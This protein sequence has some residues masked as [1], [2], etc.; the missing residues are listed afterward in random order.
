VKVR[1]QV[2]LAAILALA[3][4]G[5]AGAQAV[6]TG[7]VAFLDGDVTV[8]GKEAQVG[9]TIRRGATIQ[10]GPASVCEITWGSENIVQIQEKTL[11]ILDVGSFTPGVRLE[12]GSVAAVMNRVDAVSRRGTF[13]VKTPSA[14]AGVRGTVFFVKVE[15]KSNTYVC[16][17]YGAVDVTLTLGAQT[18]LE[19]NRHMARRFTRAGLASRSVAAGLL[20]HDDQSMGALAQKIGYT[21][22][23]GQGTHGTTKSGG[24]SGY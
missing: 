18:E 4:A 22:P 9:Q 10:T 11:A 17:C 23:W 13:R 16:A 20:Y 2:F 12:R 24:G 21:V 7:Q 5:Q 19:A 8:D 6:K 14:S 1:T 15:D 3:F